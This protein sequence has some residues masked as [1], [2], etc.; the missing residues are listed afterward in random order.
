MWSNMGKSSEKD[1]VH[2]LRSLFSL[3]NHRNK[4]VNEMIAYGTS[5]HK[6]SSFLRQKIADSRFSSK[7]TE[8]VIINLSC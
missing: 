5:K 8:K 7:V 6:N 2:E 1:I 3:I 4:S